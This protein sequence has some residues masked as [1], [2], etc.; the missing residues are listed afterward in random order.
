MEWVD[1]LIKEANRVAKEYDS[2]V[3]EQSLLRHRSFRVQREIVMLNRLLDF[4]GENPIDLSEQ[5]ANN[6]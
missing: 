5:E 2:L 1:V 3:E 4:H 6:D